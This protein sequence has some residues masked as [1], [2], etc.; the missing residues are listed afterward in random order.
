ME[1]CIFGNVLCFDTE[2]NICISFVRKDVNPIYR[3]FIDITSQNSI[4][5]PTITNVCQYICTSSLEVR[6]GQIYLFICI[7]IYLIDILAVIYLFDIY[8]IQL[9]NIC[10]C[11]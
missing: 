3:I 9:E 10:I 4:K 5:I 6:V 11:I 1:N 7:C 2:L 8:L